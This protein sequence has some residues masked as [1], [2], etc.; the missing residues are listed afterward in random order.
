MCHC[1]AFTS[2]LVPVRSPPDTDQYVDRRRWRTLSWLRTVVWL[3]QASCRHWPLR[4]LSMSGVHSGSQ[5]TLSPMCSRRRHNQW[6]GHRVSFS[7][8]AWYSVLLCFVFVHLYICCY[9]LFAFS[10]FVFYT[11]LIIVSFS[12]L[13]SEWRW[14]WHFLCV[15]L[16][17]RNC[18]HTH[19]WL[20][21]LFI[22]CQLILTADAINR[23]RHTVWYRTLC[24]AELAVSLPLLGDTI[25]STHRV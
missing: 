19:A 18:S 21:S 8:P 10:R 1:D 20:R 9:D 6:W 16:P 5:K 25:A 23:L 12:L 17:L 11:L 7:Q 2:L 3:G 22:P 4:S 13:T 14:Q 24:Y 15:D